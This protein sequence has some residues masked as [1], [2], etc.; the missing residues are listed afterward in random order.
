[1]DLFNSLNECGICSAYKALLDAGMLERQ[2]SA[3]R[4]LIINGIREWE[5]G[6]E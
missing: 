6:K 2:I 4:E 5:G 1:M 3:V